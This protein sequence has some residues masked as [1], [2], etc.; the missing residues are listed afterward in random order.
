MKHFKM[1]YPPKYIHII[2]RCRHLLTNIF[3]SQASWVLWAAAR[4][5]AHATASE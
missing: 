1:Y 5:R 2:D 3:E 4:E